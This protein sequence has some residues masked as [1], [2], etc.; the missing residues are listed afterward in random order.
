M[1]VG[2][3]DQKLNRLEHDVSFTAGLPQ[4]L[5]R[6]FRKRMQY[7]RAAVD[8]RDF[9]KMKSLHFEKLAG[10]RQHQH[11]MRLN[12]RYRLVVEIEGHSSSKRLMIVTIEDYH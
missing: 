11:S 5:V 2:F 4:G 1:E 7:I 12:E 6:V 8:E 9:Y 10:A 3:E